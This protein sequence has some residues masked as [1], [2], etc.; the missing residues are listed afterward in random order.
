MI[1]LLAIIIG[2]SFVGADAH[3]RAISVEE[4]RLYDK[5]VDYSPYQNEVTCYNKS[6]RF[7]K[8][9]WIQRRSRDF[10]LV[11]PL[12]EFILYQTEKFTVGHYDY[13]V[14]DNGSVADFSNIQDALDASRDGDRIYVCPGTYKEKI[15]I[16]TDVDLIGLAGADRTRIDASSLGDGTVVFL[17]SS[18]L[19]EGFTITGAKADSSCFYGGGIK[20]SGHSSSGIIYQTP[21]VRNNKIIDN[22]ACKVGSIFVGGFS[23]GSSSAAVYNTAT[24]QNNIITGNYSGTSNTGG[25]SVSCSKSIDTVIENNVIAYNSAYSGNAG[26]ELTGSGCTTYIRNNILFNNTSSGTQNV[27]TGSGGVIEYNN[28]YGNSTDYTSGTANINVDPVFVDE[29]DYELDS[30]SPSI[31][32]GDPDPAYDDTDGSVNDQGAYGGNNGNW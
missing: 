10:R 20:I 7:K 28:S 26:I 19:I 15:D 11:G 25:I 22:T 29:D 6:F 14:D 27:I 1:K 31:D 8:L 9:R 17:G 3:S 18:A 12:S 23:S 2:F 16:A 32:A 5:I 21:I 4:M 30:T 13:L 24:I